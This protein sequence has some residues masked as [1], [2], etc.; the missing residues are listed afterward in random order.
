[1][2]TDTDTASVEAVAADLD[3]LEACSTTDGLA[4]LL[5]ESWATAEKAAAMLR[6]LAAERDTLARR[7]AELEADGIHSCHPGCDRPVCVLVRERDALLVLAVELRKPPA[8]L[9]DGFSVYQVLPERQRYRTSPENVSDVLDAVVKIIRAT[10]P[11]DH[12]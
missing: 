7:V 5:D 3:K 9:F 6:S 2:S 10:T 12:P 11:K 1:M 4:E 8:V